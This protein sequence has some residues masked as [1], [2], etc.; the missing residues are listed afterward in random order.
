MTRR[1]IPGLLAL[2]AL[3]LALATPALQAPVSGA[4]PSIAATWKDPAADHPPYN[5]ILVVGIT[6]NAP[7][8]RRFEDLFVSVL[9]GRSLEGRTSYTLAPDLGDV[10]DPQAIV[11]T[12]F[13][14]HVDGVITVRLV[15]M[16]D[17]QEE[18]WDAAWRKDVDSGIPIRAYVA[19]SLAKL[20]PDAHWHGAELALW[21]VQSGRRLW[22]ARSAPLKVKSLRKH[23]TVLVQDTMD[24]LRSEKLL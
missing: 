18:D 1:G 7:A 21:D 5:K 24:E 3:L 9:R 20:A 4:V 15:S 22:A 16:D 10:K 19:D 17:R 11:D 14:E 8:R 12:L 2:T 23:A 6:R 13:A